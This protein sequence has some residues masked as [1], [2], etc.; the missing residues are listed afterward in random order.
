MS[1]LNVHGHTRWSDRRPSKQLLL[2]LIALLFLAHHLKENNG[3]QIPGSIHGKVT[4][5]HKEIDE[6]FTCLECTLATK[7]LG[8][9]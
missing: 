5:N 1:K 8:G 7:H 3:Q 4:K 9:K 2:W 6:M